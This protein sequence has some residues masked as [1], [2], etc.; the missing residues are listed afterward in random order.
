MRYQVLSTDEY[1]QTAILSTFTSVEEARKFLRSQVSDLN[2]ANALTTDDKFR[3]IE[4]Y[5]VEFLDDDGNVTDASLYSG[6]TTDGRPRK[7][8]RN[9]EAYSME[10][11]GEDDEVRILLGVNEDK[12]N[13]HYLSTVKNEIVNKLGH[14]LLEGKTEFF[15]RVV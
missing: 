2:F 10:V 8:V 3:T 15:I 13:P 9:G 7:L 6:N 1:G 12:N 5:G 11:V 4:A 14:E